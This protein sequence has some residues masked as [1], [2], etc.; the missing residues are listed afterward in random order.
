MARFVRSHAGLRRILDRHRRNGERIVMANG[1]FELLHVGHIRYLEAASRL[2]DI[3]VVAVNTDASVRQLKGRGRP[4]VDLAERVE[5][6]RALRCVDYVTAFGGKTCDA[7][8]S[9]IRP[10][11][12]AKGTDYATDTVPERKTVRAYGGKTVIV[13]DPK[14]HSVTDLIRRI[15]SL[16]VEARG[17]PVKRRP[18]RKA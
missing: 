6:L 2:G 16:G 9:T 14:R 18:R 5:T 3:L 8:L 1:C 15:G 4:L 17:R 11:V 12:H 10:D 13:G 7:L